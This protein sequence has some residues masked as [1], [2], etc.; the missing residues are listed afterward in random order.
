MQPTGNKSKTICGRISPYAATTIAFARTLRRRSTDSVVLSEAGCATARFISC[1]AALTSLVFSFIPRPAGRSGCVRTNTTSCPER[2]S[3]RKAL[4]AKTGVPAK[5]SRM[6]P[7]QGP[8]LLVLLLAQ[9]GQNPRL[10]EPRE[11]LDENNTFEVVHL[12]LDADRQKPIGFQLVATSFPIQRCDFDPFR[13][14]NAI[15]N[16]GYRK[17]AF[18]QLGVAPSLEDLRIDQHQQI[19]V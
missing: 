9:F 4:S 10:L 1:A 13:A 6:A 15:K 18:L 14:C 5:I 19:V 2:T 17:T 7:L 16:A 3:A 11:V 12:V 8:S